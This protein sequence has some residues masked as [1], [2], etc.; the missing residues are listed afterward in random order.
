[1]CSMSSL[2]CSSDPCW[3]LAHAQPLHCALGGALASATH[4]CLLRMRTPPSRSQGQQPPWT[5]EEEEG[6]A[7]DAWLE[8]HEPYEPHSA[9]ARERQE[10]R[11]LRMLRRRTHE[12]STEFS[13]QLAAYGANSCASGCGTATPKLQEPSLVPALV[14]RRQGSQPIAQRQERRERHALLPSAPASSRGASYDLDPHG[15]ELESL[16]CESP[17]ARQVGRLV[18]ELSENAFWLG[19]MSP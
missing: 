18:G 12:L 11:A 13:S 2:L 19:R 14:S 9:T 5:A 17:Q 1:M 3:Q 10:A 15:S 16:K 7:A 8:A 6:E 4:A